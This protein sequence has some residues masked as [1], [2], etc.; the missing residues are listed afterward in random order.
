MAPISHLRRRGG[1]CGVA[2]YFISFYIF[3][4]SDRGKEKVQTEIHGPLDPTTKLGCKQSV[5]GQR[6]RQSDRHDIFESDNALTLTLSQ[7]L[8]FSTNAPT[9]QTRQIHAIWGNPKY[10]VA[11]DIFHFKPTSRFTPCASF[12]DS[13][14][15]SDLE[16]KLGSIGAST[17][18]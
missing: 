13:S 15:P 18:P 9:L 12:F 16:S 6:T 11:C 2:R 10:R 8:K 1:P 17:L 3:D 7:L 14:A 5:L 4:M